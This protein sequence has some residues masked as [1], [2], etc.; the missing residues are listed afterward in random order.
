MTPCGAN[1]HGDMQESIG[2]ENFNGQKVLDL[3]G[4]SD[5][6]GEDPFDELELLHLFC[7]N[8]YIAP[9]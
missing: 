9:I 5:I 6:G 4:K 3:K 1:S 7:I 2:T 8:N